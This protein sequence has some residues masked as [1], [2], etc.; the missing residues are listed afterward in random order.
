MSASRHTINHLSHPVARVRLDQAPSRPRAYFAARTLGAIVGNLALFMILFQAYKVVRRSFVQRSEA[1]GYAN[2]D[3]IIDLERRL[4]LFVEVDIQQWA[5][6]HEWLIR[7]LNWNYAAFMWVFYGCCAVAIAFAPARFR[8]WRRVFICS[9]LIALPWY[10][11]YPLAPP[12]FM[13]S[14]GFVDTLKIFGPQYFKEKGGLVAAN[15]YAAMPSMHVGWTTIGAMMVATS[16]PWRRI[17]IAIGAYLVVAITVTVM[18]TGNHYL[19]DAIGGWIVVAA[20]IFVATRLPE[21]LRFP[22]LSV[23]RTRSRT[24]SA[25][26]GR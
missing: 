5:V 10:A 13:P 3:Q 25:V 16:L 1:V 8:F 15:Q 9:M 6:R 2:A 18:A 21:N 14:A 12:R 17:G 19:M 26:A 20:A 11:L 24:S 23:E 4:H 22:R 7:A